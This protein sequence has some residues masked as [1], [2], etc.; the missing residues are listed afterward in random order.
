MDVALAGLV[1]MLTGRSVYH[2][3]VSMFKD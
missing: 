2:G 1:I 3:P